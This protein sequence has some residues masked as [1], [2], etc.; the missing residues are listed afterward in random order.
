[1][2]RIYLLYVYSIKY[3]N[4][5]NNLQHMLCLLLEGRSKCSPFTFSAGRKH[6][7]GRSCDPERASALCLHHMCLGLMK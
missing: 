4:I 7:R 1:M 5:V 3:R 2:T 6:S